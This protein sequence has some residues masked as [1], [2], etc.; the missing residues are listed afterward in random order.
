MR[1]G[2][3]PLR[4]YLLLLLAAL[5]ME[6]LKEEDSSLGDEPLEVFESIL[7]LELTPGLDM[8]LGSE[9]ELTP[10][11]ERLLGSELEEASVLP[12]NRV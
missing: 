6:F 8:L 11:L 4:R 5:G 7:D 1:R 2:A 10:G 3:I 12:D 9:L